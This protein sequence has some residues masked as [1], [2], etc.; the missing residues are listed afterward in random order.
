MISYSLHGH[1]LRDMC[2]GIGSTQCI[3]GILDFARHRLV[4]SGTR[5]VLGLLGP[6]MLGLLG[7]AAPNA[8]LYFAGHL[9]PTFRE[10]LI[11]EIFL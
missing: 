2:L 11:G 1:G 7:I 3:C 4:A 6:Q 8:H 5:Q 9:F 10:F